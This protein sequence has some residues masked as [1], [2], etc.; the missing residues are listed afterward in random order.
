MPILFLILLLIVPNLSFADSKISAYPADTSPANGDVTVIVKASDSTNA[1]VALSD[2]KT[3]MGGGYS[4]I[5]Q[6]GSGNIGIN[7]TNAGANLTVK[8]TG[9]TDPFHVASSSSTALLKVINGG[10]VG[11]NT[12]TPGQ[13]LDVQG[14]IR[15][16]A[17]NLSTS[18][19]S[20]DVL[21]SDTNGNGTWQ[22]PTGTPAGTGT[23]LQYRNG[24]SFGAV[25]NST[26]DSNGNIGINTTITNRVLTV[27][28][29]VL[30][31][32][33]IKFQQI[34]SNNNQGVPIL[35]LQHA[36]T[37]TPASGIGDFLDFSTPNVAGTS[38]TNLRV[39]ATLSNVGVGTETSTVFFTVYTGGSQKTGWVMNGNSAGT[40]EFM[41]FNAGTGAVGTAP[42][43]IYGSGSTTGISLSSRV[44]AA[45]GGAINDV[46]LD[47]GN[48][49][50]GTTTPDS[51]FTIKSKST[52]DYFHANSIANGGGNIFDIS[53]GGNIGIG[54]TAPGQTLDIGPTF[55]IRDVGIGTTVT[56]ELCRKAD[57]TFGYFDGAWTGSCT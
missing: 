13:N 5:T 27:T 54:S 11:I 6:N 34:D 44:S 3:Y 7:S 48:I 53:N 21:T 9:T 4:S 23:E 12:S 52:N 36:T 2:L 42:V 8:Q 45:G 10:N 24:S 18:P 43:D 49:G 56:Q 51:S 37:G 57:G 25:S 19:V 16:T 35:V 31:A 15:M 33:P 55:K 38:F 50:I 30:G 47:N 39:N 46:I 22:L 29:T 41:S 14:T 17:F 1:K 20:G 28:G 26:V 32:T 40:G